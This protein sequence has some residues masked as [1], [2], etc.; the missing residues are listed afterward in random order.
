MACA[1][2]FV[3]YERSNE[4]HARRHMVALRGAET[5]VS[6]TVVSLCI[7]EGIETGAL[8]TIGGVREMNGAEDPGR[9]ADWS[10]DCGGYR[11]SGIIASCFGKV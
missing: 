10:G 7:G 8:G 11:P 4:G 2:S 9:R 6:C 3:L 1:Q 5:M